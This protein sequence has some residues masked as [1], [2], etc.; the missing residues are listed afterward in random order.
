MRTEDGQLKEMLATRRAAHTAAVGQLQASLEVLQQVKQSEHL[1]LE[2]STVLSVL[3]PA[4]SY[5]TDEPWLMC[6]I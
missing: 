3:L 5:T 2:E 1:C 4:V 6:T